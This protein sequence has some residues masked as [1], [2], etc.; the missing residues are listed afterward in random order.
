MKVKLNPTVESLSGSI[1]R[2]T[3][4]QNN[5]CQIGGLKPPGDT[6]ATRRA[7]FVTLSGTNSTAWAALVADDKADWEIVA[8]NYNT[9]MS[10]SK[11][12]INKYSAYLKWDGNL[13]NVPASYK[14]GI[15]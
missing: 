14:V 8:D 6:D 15:I 5:G 10:G 7:A 2:L 3:F 11:G 4:H 9:A 12:R 13:A 1:G